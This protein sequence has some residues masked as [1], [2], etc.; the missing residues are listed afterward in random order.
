MESRSTYAYWTIR[1]WIAYIT[2]GKAATLRLSLKDHLENSFSLVEMGSM[3]ITV[4]AI[5]ILV[6]SVAIT[7]K[8]S[9]R[10]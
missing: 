7:Y 9:M 3:A 10:S 6:N 8:K 4:I 5:Q 1:F 2:A